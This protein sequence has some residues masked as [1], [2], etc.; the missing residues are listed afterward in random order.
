VSARYK[1]G[2]AFYSLGYGFFITAIAATK[3]SLLKKK[4]SLFLDYMKGFF[5]AKFSNKPM[6]VTP[7][8]A[9]FIR[10]YRLKKMLQ[11]IG[12]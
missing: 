1:Q 9:K 6:L 2:E 11:K 10:K 5:K 12:I 7:K 4:P 3:L 8:Q